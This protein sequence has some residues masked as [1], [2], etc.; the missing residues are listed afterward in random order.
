MHRRPNSE[1]TALRRD[2][3]PAGTQR[4]HSRARRRARVQSRRST[5]GRATAAARCAVSQASP[6]GSKQARDFQRQPTKFRNAGHKVATQL[7]FCDRKEV[8]RVVCVALGNELAVAV[9]CGVDLDDTVEDTR[10]R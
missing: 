1:T 6:L 4:S 5:S 8:L 3:W 9:R 2:A 10:M 7:L